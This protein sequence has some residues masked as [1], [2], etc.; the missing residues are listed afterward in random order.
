[1]LDA[2]GKPTSRGAVIV[3][4]TAPRDWSEA[5]RRIRLARPDTAG[6]YEISGLPPGPYTVSAVTAL[7]PGQLW[8]AAFL[9]TLAKSQQIELSQGQTATVDLR[10]K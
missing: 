6:R 5:T 1:M 3:A 8:D 2:A 7:A 10:L 4:S 9:K